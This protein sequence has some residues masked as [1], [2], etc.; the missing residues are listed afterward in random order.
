MFGRDPKLAID[1]WQH[2]EVIEDKSAEGAWLKN[3]WNIQEEVWKI[4]KENMEK[5]TGRVKLK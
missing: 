5:K 2:T 1:G 4:A 3:Q